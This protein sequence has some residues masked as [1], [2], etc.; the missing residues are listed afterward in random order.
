M[1]HAIFI[2]IELHENQIPNLDIAVAILLRRARRAARHAGA[3]IVEKLGTRATRAGIAHS[4]EVIRLILARTRLIANARQA[5]RRHTDFVQPNVGC[6][7]VLVI[8]RDPQFFCGNFHLNREE[9]PRVLNRVALEIIAETEIAQ[10]LEKSMMA[11]GIT[12]VFQIVM[13]AAG[14]HAALRT[15]GA[16]IGPGFTAKERF[17]ELHHAGVGEEQRRIIARHERTRGDNGVALGFEK[18]QKTFADFT[19]FHCGFLKAANMWKNIMIA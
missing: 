1:H 17:F 5:L 16:H 13:L 19:G 4:P 15:G 7:V 10:H 6:F 8:H 2:A 18:G 14:T 3:V 11:R 12:D 9:F